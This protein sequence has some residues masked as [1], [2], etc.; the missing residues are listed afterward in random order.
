LKILVDHREKPLK[1]LLNEEFHE[2]SFVQLPVAD[3]ILAFD[4][5]AIAIERKTA[6]DFLSSVRSNRLWEQLLRLMKTDK[7][8]GFK[9]KRKILLLHGNFE[10]LFNTS[11]E[12]TQ[13]TMK[14]WS[15]LMGA[16]MEV[17]YVYNT[18]VVHAEDDTAFMAF[19]RILAKR[20]L[21]GKNDK[22]PNG[23]WYRK[24]ARLDLPTKDRKRY[25][26]SAI[27]YI[28]D[29][30]ARNLLTHYETISKIACAS[31]EDLQKV[32]K[33]GRKKAELIHSTFH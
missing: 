13:D 31:V 8:M 1:K 16:L 4:S 18:P 15:Q 2:V 24:P 25:V 9:V 10:H 14:S 17:I 30:L 3:Y 26:L 19:M 28:G 11:Y 7:I 32:P 20:E 12:S 23:R 22:L 6:R 21:S 29:K 27:P 33:I 5:E